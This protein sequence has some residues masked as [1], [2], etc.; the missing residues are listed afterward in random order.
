MEG[1][2][3]LTDQQAA[4]VRQSPAHCVVFAAPG[5]GK[6]TVL[7]EH[8]AWLLQTGQLRAADVLALTFTRQSALDMKQRMRERGTVGGATV[9]A[10]RLGTFHGQAFRMLLSRQ[11][12]IPV[13]LSPLEQFQL[14]RS[15]AERVGDAR[16]TSVRR[17]LLANSLAKAVWPPEGSAEARVR[18]VLRHYER[19][20]VGAHRWDFD[21]ILVHFA[22]HLEETPALVAPIRYL[23]VD[24]Y[25]DTNAMQWHIVKQ[26]SAHAGCPVFVVGD[27]DQSIYGFRGASP[28]GLLTFEAQFET[29]HPHHLST[30][31]RSCRSIVAAAGRLISHNVRRVDKTVTAF[32]PR[33]GFC[34]V[35]SWKDERAQADGVIGLVRSAYAEDPRLTIAILARTRRELSS[36]WKAWGDQPAPD[37]EL[38]FRTFH[39][40][41]GKEWDIV[42]IVGA[43]DANP[44]LRDD[45]TTGLWRRHVADE[46]EERRLFYVAATRAR[47]QLFMHIPSRMRNGRVRASRYIGEAGL[48]LDDR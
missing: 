31:F 24:E 35:R 32:S 37:A 43:V 18:A 47:A 46:E 4:I 1:A 7:T 21:D 12:N 27:D 23:L 10:L 26:I 40:A 15:A 42:H 9:E 2:S 16:P 34:R 5:S 36:L 28:R 3:L 48:Q 8:I 38:Q 19:L 39:D 33:E 6:T 29:A 45:P 22:H 17:Y 14:M 25:Q 13:L 11:A 30:N 41:K 20:K 44:Y